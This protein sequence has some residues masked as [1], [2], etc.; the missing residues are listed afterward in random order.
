MRKIAKLILVSLLTSTGFINGCGS[1]EYDIEQ[2]DIN[3]IETTVKIDTLNK[4]SDENIKIGNDRINLQNTL[5]KFS[6]QVGA[7][8]TPSYFENFYAQ[9]RQVLGNEVYYEIISNLYKIRIGSFNN[10]PEAT[11]V[12]ELARSKGY[13]DAF[14]IIKKR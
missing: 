9:A 10:R 3:Y 7:F 4:I 2:Y 5:Y 12:V 11:K 6:V 1:G 13:L 8:V 14:I